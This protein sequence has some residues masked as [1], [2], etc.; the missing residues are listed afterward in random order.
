VPAVGLQSI[1]ISTC[2]NND[3]MM[4]EGISEEILL[5]DYQ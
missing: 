5:P 3:N 2:L 1:Y 4:V